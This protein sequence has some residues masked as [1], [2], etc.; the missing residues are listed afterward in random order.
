MAG[1][2]SA[3]VLT[4][5]G[6]ETVLVF[7][8]GLDLRTSLPSRCL[9]P[10]TVELFCVGIPWFLQLARDRSAAYVLSSPTWRANPDWGALLGYDAEAL[11]AINSRAIWFL[12]E[13]R[14]DIL[15]PEERG[16]VVIEGCVGPR[17]DA[18][19]PT[20]RM[21]AEAAATTTVS[22]CERSPPRVAYRRPL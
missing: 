9:I 2:R 17:S 10:T 18:Y 14:D 6:L 1:D 15:A 12:E 13:L 5:A 8:D 4:D 22:S 19:R 11:A 7:E 3:L 16:S 20:M 21:D